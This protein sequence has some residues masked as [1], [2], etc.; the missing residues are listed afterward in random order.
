MKD[1]KENLPILLVCRLA[2]KSQKNDKD[3]EKSNCQKNCERWK[4]LVDALII[5]TDKSV[6]FEDIVRIIYSNKNGDISKTK[7]FLDCKKIENKSDKYDITRCNGSCPFFDKVKTSIQ[8]IKR[9]LPSNIF[10]EYLLQIHALMG[11]DISDIMFIQYFD[12]S[13]KTN[14]VP[15]PKIDIQD[16]VNVPVVEGIFD[17]CLLNQWMIKIRYILGLTL[18]FITF[19]IDQILHFYFNSIILYAI[20]VVLLIANYLYTYHINTAHKKNNNPKGH[21]CTVCSSNII[22]YQIF[23]DYILLGGIIFATGGMFSPVILFFLPHIIF[24]VILLRGIKRDINIV[25][26][27]VILGIIMIFQLFGLILDNVIINLFYPFSKNKFILFFIWFGISIYIL[28]IY[29]FTLNISSEIKK[30]AKDIIELSKMMEERNRI[31]LKLNSFL[32]SIDDMR[33]RMINVA[34]H[35]L[36]SPLAVIESYINIMLSGYIGNLNEKQEENLKKIQHRIVQM[37]ELIN[38]I[39]D[40]ASLQKDGIATELSPIDVLPILNELK[41]DME[42]VAS[43]NEVSLIFGYPNSIPLIFTSKN[44][45]IQVVQN[46]ITNAIKFTPRGGIVTMKVLPREDD[47]LFSISDTGIGIPPEDLENIFTE[48]YR[49][50]ALNNDKSKGS[51]LGLYIVKKIIDAHDGK[52]WVESE[53]GKGSTFYFTM[54]RAGLDDTYSLDKEFLLPTWAGGSKIK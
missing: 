4:R 25:I 2:C 15:Y 12:I 23:I 1:L 7:C 26:P 24:S 50:K 46:L 21:L 38:E 49:V 27:I 52:I 43:K 40:V 6:N 54:K 48:F 9:E 10:K 35:D 51:G 22:Q 36:K 53:I 20:S 39:L 3:D 17:Y 45:F 8:L 41:E 11:S 32:E 18:V 33:Q 37:R 28:I 34:S 31:I 16:L 47:V 19:I 5:L 13:E 14:T 44:R 42:M 30:R 29:Y